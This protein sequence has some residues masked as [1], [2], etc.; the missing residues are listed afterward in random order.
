MTAAVAMPVY[1]QAA[2]AL[3]LTHEANIAY[4]AAMS[5]VHDLINLSLTDVSVLCG[6]PRTFAKR[7]RDHSLAV[8]VA[9]EAFVGAIAT[10][11]RKRS[12]GTITFPWA[13]PQQQQQHATAM[14][15]SHQQM[16]G[17]GVGGGV[18]AVM[19]S[20][21]L[22]TIAASSP[23]LPQPPSFQSPSETANNNNHIASSFQNTNN[24]ASTSEINASSALVGGK[25][26]PL[27][28][29]LSSS[30]AMGFDSLA[31]LTKADE[32][33][34]LVIEK[35][36]TDDHPS[37][38]STSMVSSGIASPS[39]GAI[40]SSAFVA[41]AICLFGS[42]RSPSSVRL[43]V[44]QGA[45]GSVL[46]TGIALNI[47]PENPSSEYG[48]MLCFPI[49]KSRDSIEP[50]GAVVVE[51]KISKT[52]SQNP[53]GTSNAINNI[54]PFG[55]VDEGLVEGYCNLVAHLLCGYNQKLTDLQFDTFD[56]FKRNGATQLAAAYKP[57]QQDESKN[58]EVK[59]PRL[60]KSLT[61]KGVTSLPQLSDEAISAKVKAALDSELGTSTTKAKSGNGIGSMTELFLGASARL[62]TSG[63]HAGKL[64]ALLTAQPRLQLVLHSAHHS[65][66]TKARIK[67]LQGTLTIASQ[68]IVDVA[69]YISTIEECWR[70]SADDVQALTVNQM[71]K[72]DDS[73]NVRKQLREVRDRNAR[74]ETVAN[75][76]KDRYE[77]LRR[78]LTTVCDAPLEEEGE[79]EVDTAPS[80]SANHKRY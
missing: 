27:K 50:I 2:S 20:P 15:S 21:R 48:H 65:H 18:S 16:H 69:A 32:G 7:T 49:F 68:N 72:A 22:P 3:E 63:D 62:G 45:I 78:E 73:R 60:S 4:R 56:F 26:P 53:N 51:K 74:L 10:D 24:Y 42:Q 36:S 70:R 66:F 77:D 71:A 76:Y 12:T 64:A 80:I 54:V 52:A 29:T 57:L 58:R 46:R 75:A 47:A 23:R 39:N 9:F 5:A 19:S 43:P 44:E 67:P 33:V 61:G 1:L 40:S 14:P 37:A 13:L 35:K 11:Q 17:P 79:E 41:Q 31:R 8:Q 28:T 59:N 38:T 6:D 25:Y 34:L 30:I 55:P